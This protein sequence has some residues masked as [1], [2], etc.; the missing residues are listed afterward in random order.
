MP[1]PSERISDFLIAWRWPLF[2]LALVA[3]AAALW[4]AGNLGFDRSIENMFAPDDPLLAPYQ[5]LKSSFG[6]NEIVLAVYDDP[7]L[8]NADGR[9]MRRLEQLGMRLRK[10]PACAT[11]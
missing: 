4:P 2:A 11:S 10:Y 6:G 7:E 8:M 1:T 9:G 3:V 5:K